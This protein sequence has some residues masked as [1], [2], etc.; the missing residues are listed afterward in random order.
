MVS[1]INEMQGNP[2]KSSPILSRNKRIIDTNWSSEQIALVFSLRN[3]G[4]HNHLQNG[5]YDHFFFSSKGKNSNISPEFDLF[6]KAFLYLG[7]KINKL[8]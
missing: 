5:L 7:L 2:S 3:L 1:D 8:S 6:I 4:Y